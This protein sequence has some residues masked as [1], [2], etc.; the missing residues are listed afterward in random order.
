MTAQVT[1]SARRTSR[2]ATALL[3]VA[4]VLAGTL[5]PLQ[6]LVNGELGTTIDDGNSAAV[7]SFGSG[8]VIVVLLVS[9]RPVTRRQA[10]DLP[11]LIRSGGLGWWNYLAG[12]CGA[13]VVLSEGVT[14][15]V[16]GVAVFQITLISGLVIS[17]VI[18]DRVGIGG[19]AK[20]P[21]SFARLAGAVL[22]VGATVLVV[23]PGMHVAGGVALAVL[24]FAA[25]LLAGWQPAGNAAVAQATGS[26]LVSVGFNFLVGFVV[27][28]AG[29]AV[30]LS[31]GIGHFALPA[32]WWLYTGGALGLLSIGFM[33]LLVRGLGLLLLGL[34]SV[35]GQLVG[36][37]ALDAI[38][39]SLGEPVHLVT[40]IGTVIALV[41]A[42]TAMLPSRTSE[43]EGKP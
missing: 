22:A 25:G 3:V 12:L 29:L 43:P 41:A 6:S 5:S 4:T 35:A 26:M 13:A 28:L 37:L 17:G 23:A 21:I 14:V 20:Q 33:A 38:S 31:L 27:L 15:G 30:R 24:P 16:L 11:R 1:P 2:A 36:S 10:R 34:A 19:V 42:G 40:V 7:I 39:P 18:C 9:A 8:L 32:T